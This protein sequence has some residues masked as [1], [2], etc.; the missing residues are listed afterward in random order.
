M[1]IKLAKNFLS[2]ANPPFRY[3]SEATFKDFCKIVGVNEKLAIKLLDKN[4]VKIGSDKESIKDIAKSNNIT[5][6]ELYNIIKGDKKYRLPLDLPIG[7]AHKSIKD[8]EKEYGI[9]ID[10]FLKYL[11]YYGIKANKDITFKRLAKENSLHPAKL[12]SMLYASQLN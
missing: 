3:A 8:L 2:D 12:Y 1:E 11:K 4:S 6:K 7:I 5:P 9:D 10:K